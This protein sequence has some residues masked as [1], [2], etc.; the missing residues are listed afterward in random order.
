MA[1][2]ESGTGRIGLPL[3]GNTYATKLNQEGIQAN[4]TPYAG[5]VNA[6]AT[7]IA[8]TIHDGRVAAGMPAWG[9]ANGGPLNDSQIEELVTMIQHVDWNEVYNESLIEENGNYYYPTAAPNDPRKTP[10][11]AGAEA[12][13]TPSDVGGGADV[14]SVEMVD[15]S[16]NPKEITIPANTDVTINLANN[17]AANHTFDIDALNIHS[18]E[19]AA[20][21]TGSI[22]INA[23]PGEYEYYCATP[24][25]KESGMVGKLI[26]Q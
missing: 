11:P 8:E 5:G 4:G 24:G 25:H 1:P 14:Q 13:S 23:A 19:Y 16:F 12:T 22:T 26:V 15:I 2:G 21:E 20:G 3:G 17:G 10:T 18:G 9:E 7:V 6:R